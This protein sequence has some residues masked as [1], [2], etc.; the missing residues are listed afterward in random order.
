MPRAC[1]KAPPSLARTV[2]DGN[3]YQGPRILDPEP[4]YDE[5]V[6]SHSDY[7]ITTTRCVFS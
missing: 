2:D 1:R 4:R 5:Q 6:A 7:L 3:K